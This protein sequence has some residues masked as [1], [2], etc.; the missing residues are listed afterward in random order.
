MRQALERAAALLGEPL[1]AESPV[2]V[3]SDFDGTLSQIVLDP[4]GAQI[5][6]LARRAL[7]Q[8]SG[9]PGVQVALL[10]GR[11]AADVAARVRIGGATYL[12]NHGVETG[13]LVRRQRAGSLAVE[14]FAVPDEYAAAADRL[15]AEVPRVIPEPWLVV[16]RKL[17]AVAFHFRG[18]PDPDAA[19]AA[20]REAVDA[21]DPDEMLVRYP[22]RRV[23]ELR[24]P[25]VPDKGTAMA[26]LLT[27]HS[28]RVCFA[29]GD[30]ISDAAAFRTLKEARDTSDLTGLALA[31]QARREAPPAVAAA[32]DLVL[33]SPIE[34]ARFLSG[35]AR[36]LSTHP[37]RRPERQGPVGEPMPS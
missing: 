28:P 29:L 2:L 16:E 11:T 24:P 5:L 25:G 8:L 1:S 32:A 33:A 6:P 19:G 37:P 21:L 22:G 18:A 13:R 17:P 14:V 34:A 26:A 3:V 36:L 12:G 35:L 23:L 9:T 27:E 4:W 15:A 20:V 10:S 31:I 30:D 7:R